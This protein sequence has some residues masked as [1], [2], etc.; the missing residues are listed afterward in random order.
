MIKKC[1]NRITKQRFMMLMYANTG[2]YIHLAQYN[3]VSFSCI[4]I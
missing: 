4:H 3:T 2:V 1:D